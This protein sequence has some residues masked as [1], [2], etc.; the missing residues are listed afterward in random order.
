MSNNRRKFIQQVALGA[1]GISLGNINSAF[2]AKS[3]AR[4]IGAND[5][6]NVALMGCGRRVS[7]YYAALKDKNNNVDVAYI[8][9]VMK[10][11]R[12]KVGRDLQGK[13]TGN[14]K[15]VNDIHDVWNDKTVDAIFNATPDH[16]HAPGTWMAMQAGK[17][18]YIEKP[19][20][21]NPREGELLVAF[22]KKYGKV[23][24][25]GNQQRSAKESQDIISEIHKGV[26]GDVYKAVAFYSNERGEVPIEKKAPIPEGLDWNLWQG[27]APHQE[28]TADT[29]DY[30][31]H[32][33]GWHWGTG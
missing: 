28:Y 1:A 14:A 9:D 26:I 4:I 10:K 12:E 25:M 21:Q 33:Y 17:H 23:V 5:R 27:P 20:S 22:Q 31:W 29:W 13:V 11:Q 7:A 8:C 16:W 6:L 3:Y 19:C 18:V 15:L 32:W 30:N 2:S 24:Q